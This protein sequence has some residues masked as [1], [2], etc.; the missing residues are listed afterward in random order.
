V[1][2][3]APSTYADGVLRIRADLVGEMGELARRDHPNETCGVVAG[4]AGSG[5][6]ERLVPMDN[7]AAAPGYPGFYHAETDTLRFGD[8][9]YAWE[10]GADLR[11]FRELDARDEDLVVIYHSHAKP[12]SEA[13]P[14]MIDEEIAR[15]FPDAHH[16]IVGLTDPRA[17]PVV[18]SYRVA[19]GTLVEEAVEVVESYM[20]AHT[21][22][23][24]VP[25]HA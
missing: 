16:V 17:E 1:Q 2:R 10:S 13:Y 18:R 5:R 20:F 7:A 25:D 4:P 15:S 22:A 8:T 21:G 11:L 24:D 12:G 9:F 23:D 3:R 19:D 14:S 6:A